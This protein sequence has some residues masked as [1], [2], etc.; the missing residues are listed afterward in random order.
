MRQIAILGWFLCTA[1]CAGSAPRVESAP[2]LTPAQAQAFD[3]GVDF[4]ATLDGLEGR[5]RDDWDRDLSTRVEIANRIAL[6]TVR[7]LRTDLDPQQ[8][9]TYRLVAEVDRELVGREGPKE[10]ELAVSAEER[11]FSS[12]H[13]NLARIADRQYIAYVTAGPDG[14]SWHLSPATPQVV[15][16]TE[17]KITALDRGVKQNEGER[18]IVHTN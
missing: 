7:T 9:V 4:V 10:I 14:P 6:V 15:S 2:P 17:S 18:V 11:G 16:E 13:E 8:Q 3:H 1:S 5:W 12:V